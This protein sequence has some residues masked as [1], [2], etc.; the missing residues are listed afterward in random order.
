[1]TTYDTVTEALSGLKT[2]GYKIDFNLAFD[3]V[4]CKESGIFLYPSD[5]EITEF[6]RFEGM[7]DPGDENTV[8]AVES[9]DGNVK[10]VLVAAHGTYSEDIDTDML[11]KLAVHTHQ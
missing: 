3:R 8:Y 9:K 10:G 2:R 4:I 5:F 1:M 11:R 7:T 6:H